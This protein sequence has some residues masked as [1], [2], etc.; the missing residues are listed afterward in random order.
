MRKSILVWFTLF[1]FLT[2]SVSNGLLVHTANLDSG[3]QFSK[4]S[5]AQQPDNDGD[6]TDDFNDPDDDND[7]YDDILERDCGSDP[8]NPMSTPT[9]SDKDDDCDGIDL[10]DDNDGFSDL[11]EIECLTDPLDSSDTPLDTDGDGVCD[12]LD[13]FPNDVT[14]WSDF[15]GDGIGDNAD[16]DDDNDG[17]LD[18][19][20]DFP[21]DRCVAEDWDGDGLPD[22]VLTQDCIFRY[23]GELDPDDDNDGVLDYADDLPRD[24]CA[25]LDTDNDGLPDFIHTNKDC[26]QSLADNDDDNDG[27]PDKGDAFPTDPSEWFDT[28]GDGIGNNADPNDDG[29]GWSDLLELLCETDPLEGSNFP[30]DTDGDG[31]CNVLD[32]DDDNDGILDV[33][34]PFPLDTEGS[35]QWATGA[36]DMIKINDMAM[37]SSG[38]ILV[39]GSYKGSTSLGSFTLA[40]TGNKGDVFVAKMNDQGDWLWVK[41][42]RAVPKWCANDNSPEYTTSYSVSNSTGFSHTGVYVD[43]LGAPA[44]LDFIF[45]NDSLEYANLHFVAGDL[46]YDNETVPPTFIGVVATSTYDR[47]DFMDEVSH[48]V[49]GGAE[50]VKLDSAQI[51]ITNSI[52]IAIGQ[53]QFDHVVWDKSFG[54]GN[55]I[56]IDDQDNAYVTGTFYGF[57]GFGSSGGNEIESYNVRNAGN[58]LRKQYIE[59]DTSTNEDDLDSSWLSNYPCGAPHDYELKRSSDTF[60]AKISPSGTWLWANGAGGPWEDTGDHIVLSSDGEHG[61]IAGK[62]R[63]D[64]SYSFEQDDPN[65]NNGCRPLQHEGE[66]VLLSNKYTIKNQKGMFGGDGSAISQLDGCGAYVAKFKMTNGHWKD[67]MQISPPNQVMYH[68]PGPQSTIHPLTELPNCLGACSDNGAIIT[69]IVSMGSPER[70]YITGSFAKAILVNGEYAWTSSTYVKSWFIAKISWNLE[71]TDWVQSGPSSQVVTNEIHDI[72]GNGVYDLYIS[73]CQDGGKFVGLMSGSGVWSWTNAFDNPPVGTPVGTEGCEPTQIG[74]DPLNGPYVTGTY[75][76]NSIEIG[77]TVLEHSA[78]IRLGHFVAHWDA[79]GNFQWAED[80]L[81]ILENTGSSSGVLMNDHAQP[82]GIL[83]DDSSR[84]YTCGWIKGSAFFKNDVLFGDTAYVG[85]IDGPL[86]VVE[87]SVTIDPDGTAIIP[88]VGIL[89]TLLVVIVAGIFSRK[90]V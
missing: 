82:T 71:D 6:G 39:T 68:L 89:S 25:S 51:T 18:S 78:P 15:D 67:R 57:L 26:D 8:L 13:L 85:A 22:Y 30:L 33:D 73:G 41:S 31:I 29:D 75:T 47:I 7:G 56:A 40:P 48:W 53:G 70:L 5:E 65:R 43:E 69:G 50:L 54:V 10:D 2:M 3:H 81:H 35:W 83:V 9:F 49:T 58:W 45:V 24:P 87:P 28:D 19:D 62:L 44:G 1:I 86:V 21:F 79:S 23:A 36:G 42:S 37:D 32:T 46:V 20:D 59:G 12:L 84:V 80:N 64:S 76:Q 90:Q 88:N 63:H 17:V 66:Y 38:D 72:V 74:L 14:E 4:T 16:D 52:P 55:A 34:D 11:E 77:G 27:Y 60:V 61:F